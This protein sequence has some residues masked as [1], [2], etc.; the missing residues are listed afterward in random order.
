MDSVWCFGGAFRGDVAGN[1]GDGGFDSPHFWGAP[2]GGCGF[3]DFLLC[4][5]GFSLT[6]FAK[7]LFLLGLL[8]KFLL[9]K[10]L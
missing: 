2:P 9:A 3:G 10:E 4:F 5:V 7:P 6:I 1:R 8:V